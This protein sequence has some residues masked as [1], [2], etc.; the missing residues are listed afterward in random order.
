M[1]LSPSRNVRPVELEGVAP[2]R[3]A[4]LEQALE[5][6]EALKEYDA[7]Q[8][9]S[10]LDVNPQRAMELWDAYRQ[11][12]ADRAGTPAIASYCG[13]A[14]QNLDVPGLRGDDLAFAE[15]HVRIFSALYG[16]LRPFDGILPHRLGMKREFTVGGKDLYSFWGDRLYREVFR[17]NGPIISLTSQ[18]YMKLLSPCL[19]PENDVYTCRFLLPKPGGPRGTVSTVR[20]ARGQMARFI[21]E[22]RIDDPED[23]KDFDR[24]N[25]RY[26]RSASTSRCFVFV[27]GE[28]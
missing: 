13:A 2:G 12:S 16:L 28:E 5:I 10:L 26:V 23:L 24:G 1:L 8:L 3:P 6:V 4:F 25:Y 9:E 18:D 15:E 11:F 22:N 19:Q 14:Y 7:W 17:D 21:V 20:T 27:R